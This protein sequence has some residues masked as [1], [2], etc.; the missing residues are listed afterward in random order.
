MYRSITCHSQTHGICSTDP[1]FVESWLYYTY[2]KLIPSHLTGCLI[3]SFV[4]SNMVQGLSKL[5]YRLSR[6]RGGQPFGNIGVTSLNPP[7]TRL[8]RLFSHRLFL[9]VHGRLSLLFYTAP[10]FYTEGYIR[11]PA[12]IINLTFDTLAKPISED[13]LH[14]LCSPS[15]PRYPSAGIGV[16]FLFSTDSTCLNPSARLEDPRMTLCS[17][18]TCLQLYSSYCS[19]VYLCPRSQIA[20]QPCRLHVLPAFYTTRLTHISLG[21]LRLCDCGL[22]IGIFSLSCPNNAILVNSTCR[23]H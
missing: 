17:V 1:T 21:N 11:E 15:F 13:D 14:Q 9:Y 7:S 6:E 18:D 2:A 10:E 19:T 22:G 4:E 3:L 8:A 12:H 16:V 5:F 20:K 23:L